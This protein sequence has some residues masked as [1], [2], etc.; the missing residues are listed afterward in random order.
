MY[1]EGD[2]RDREKTEVYWRNSKK[3]TAKGRVRGERK[4]GQDNLEK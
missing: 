4:K 3:N 1:L 2:R